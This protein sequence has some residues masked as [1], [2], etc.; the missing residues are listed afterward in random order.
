ME[1]STNLAKLN[2]AIYIKELLT[3]NSI[4]HEKSV[5]PVLIYLL[6]NKFLNLAPLLWNQ[7]LYYNSFGKNKGK[8]TSFQKSDLWF[9]IFKKPK[10]K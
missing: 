8:E 2:E 3:M 7:S 4:H 5:G 6:K 10:K 1:S 9:A